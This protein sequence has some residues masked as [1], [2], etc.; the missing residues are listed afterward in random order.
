MPVVVFVVFQTLLS[1]F[2]VALPKIQPFEFG[3]EP[4]YL[5]DSASV[6]CYIT[7]GDTPIDFA[8]KLNNRS[9]AEINGITVS[10]FGK[11]TSVLTIDSL[12]ENHAGNY[13]C[14]ATNR[15]GFAA[16]SAELIV[17]GKF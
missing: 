7:S 6:Q 4:S 16:Y 5:G 11:K 10:T 13:T 1:P 8:W 15:A 12:A 17:K 9:V 3:N 14:V 2:F